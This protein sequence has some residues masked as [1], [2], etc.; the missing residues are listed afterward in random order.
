MALKSDAAPELRELKK[1]VAAKRSCPTVPLEVP[2]RESKA[3][4]AVERAVRTWQEQFRTL[5]SHLESGIDMTI[6]REH[7]ILQ[8]CAWWAASLL[9]RVAIKSHGRTVFEYATG[10]RMKT[11]L[12][13][14]WQAVLSRAKR[15]AGALNK[16]DSEWSDGVFLGVSGMGICVLVGTKLGIVRT[17]DYRMAP[18]GKWSRQLVLDAATTFEQRIVP[19]ADA[20]TVVFDAPVDTPV[21]APP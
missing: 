19:T 4:G 7:P 13:C 18:E 21:G 14:F 16:Y 5:K 10:H 11:Q 9:N 20:D 15:H 8:W 1:L 6:P 17:T 3:N 12:A 2:A